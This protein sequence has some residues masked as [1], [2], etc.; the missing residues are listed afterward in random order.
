MIKF[1]S[2]RA[3]QFTLL[4]NYDVQTPQFNLKQVGTKPFSKRLQLEPKFHNTTE[5]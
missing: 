5:F 2:L 4:H 1:C 3:L